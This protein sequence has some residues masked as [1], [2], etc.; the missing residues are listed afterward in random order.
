MFYDEILIKAE[1]SC[2]SEDKFSLH[3]GL[4]LAKYRLLVKLF[5]KETEDYAKTL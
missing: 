2:H 5:E 4:K 3:K 1:A